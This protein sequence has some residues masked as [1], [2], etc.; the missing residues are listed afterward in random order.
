MADNR[1]CGIRKKLQKCMLCV[2]IFALLLL[3][4]KSDFLNRGFGEGK[5][6]D[7]R[8]ERTI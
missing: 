1:I 2:L 6:A 8:T 3:L 4:L 7:C 5:G